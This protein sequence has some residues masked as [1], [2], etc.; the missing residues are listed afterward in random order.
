MATCSIGAY[1]A[2][3]T[4][5]HVITSAGFDSDL[6]Q[7]NPGLAMAKMATAMNP[8]WETVSTSDRNGT[9]TV[10]EKSTGKT[11]SLK[12]DPDSKKMVVIGDDGKQA[13]VSLSGEGANAGVAVTS[14]D[15]SVKF[16]TAA[17]NTLPSWVPVYPGSTPQGT[18]SSTSA[19]GTQNTYTFKTKDSAGKVI[20]YYTDSLKTAGFKIAMTTTTDQGGMVQASDEASKRTVIMTVGSSSD[21]T[22]ASVTSIEKK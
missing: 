15:G 16:G 20:T 11:I 4:A 3:R 5:K 10:R 18:M 2:Y 14:A 21:G 19:E 12:F 17:S 22:E 8:D 1:M 6:M 9:I 7:K 13:T